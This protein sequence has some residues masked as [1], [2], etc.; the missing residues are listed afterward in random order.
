MEICYHVL[1]SLVRP[2][3]EAMLGITQ[4]YDSLTSIC[5]ELQLSNTDDVTFDP[6]RSRIIED[7]EEATTAETSKRIEEIEQRGL[8]QCLESQ[9]VVLS[10]IR[11][12][13]YL[14]LV[15]KQRFI[16]RKL[17]FAGTTTSLPI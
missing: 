15:K 7:V 14:V 2:Q 1:P 6:E 13:V 9:V 11:T 5:I 8:H 10:R 12:N 4:L 16:E 3:L 17:C